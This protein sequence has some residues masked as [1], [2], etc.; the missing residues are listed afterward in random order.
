MPI[1]ITNFRGGEE[2]Q[3]LLASQLARF[4]QRLVNVDKLIDPNS[5][6]TQEVGLVDA[7]A[8]LDGFW[9]GEQHKLEK[10]R[11]RMGEVSR[12]IA[13]KSKKKE[14][15]EEEKA[16]VAQLKAENAAL[17]AQVPLIRENLDKLLSQV[18]LFTALFE[19]RPDMNYLHDVLW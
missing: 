2:Y 11:Q 18:C 8:R 14:S 10:G 7:I 15:F 12:A 9:K 1:D 5:T 13:E 6:S 4:D 19:L 17:E 16:T 3:S